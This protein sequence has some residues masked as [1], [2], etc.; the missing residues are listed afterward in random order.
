M[1]TKLKLF[2]LWIAAVFLAEILV[3]MVPTVGMAIMGIL[4]AIPVFLVFSLLGQLPAPTYTRDDLD[5]ARR[6]GHSAGYHNGRNN[7]Y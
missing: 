4:A 7:P 5:S 1:M 6:A 3:T 2:L